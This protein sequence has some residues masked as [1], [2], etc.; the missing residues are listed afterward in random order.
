MAAIL[1][2]D[3]LLQTPKRDCPDLNASVDWTGF[4]ATHFISVS[5]RGSRATVFLNGRETVLATF[6]PFHQFA[7]YP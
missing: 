2:A 4:V 7:T 6:S 1:P 5:K 3:D